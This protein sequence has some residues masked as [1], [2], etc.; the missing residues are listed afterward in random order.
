[1]EIKPVLVKIRGFLK[2]YR[3]AVI[4]LIIG[5]A[6]MLIPSGKKTNSVVSETKQQQ[7]A[8]LSDTT[9]SQLISVLSQIKGVGNVQLLLTLEDNGETVF[10]SD[11]DNSSNESSDNTKIETVII[12]GSDRNQSGLIKIQKSPTYRG[13]VVV[14]TGGDDPNVQF[15][16]TQAVMRSTNLNADQICV[17][18][19][20]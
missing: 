6:L 5:I 1:M 12:S 2:N 16:V 3:Y 4:V 15:A 14:C 19:M 7:D 8:K 17:L 13:A 18:K 10:Q 11:V 20:K 9:Q